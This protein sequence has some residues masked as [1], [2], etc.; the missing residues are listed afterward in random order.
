MMELLFSALIHH[1]LVPACVCLEF[2]FA[3]SFGWT[4]AGRGN[5]TDCS[6]DHGN[7]NNPLEAQPHVDTTEL[8]KLTGRTASPSCVSHSFPTGFFQLPVQL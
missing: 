7:M 4:N 3:G 8:L 2:S 1:V 6:R 5:Q